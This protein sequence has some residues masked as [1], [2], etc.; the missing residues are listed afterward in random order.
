MAP[1]AG[2]WLWRR[3]CGQS[4]APLVRCGRNNLERRLVAVDRVNDFERHLW[5]EARQ[6]TCLPRAPGKRFRMA[7]TCGMSITKIT[8]LAA[9]RSGLIGEA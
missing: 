4:A 5:R 1:H 3:A 7:T 6:E 8:S 9:T 2:A